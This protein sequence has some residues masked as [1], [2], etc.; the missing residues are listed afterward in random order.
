MADKINKN[1]YKW[2][3]ATDEVG[4]L[5]Y[6]ITSGLDRAYYYI[7]DSNYKKLGKGKNPRELEEKYFGD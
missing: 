3:T 7:Y 1:E 2:L 5:K 6:I 4:N